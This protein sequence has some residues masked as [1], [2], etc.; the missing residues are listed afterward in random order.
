MKVSLLHKPMVRDIILDLEMW[1]WIS[2]W[3]NISKVG[4]TGLRID[5]LEKIGWW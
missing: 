5:G 2:H 1:Q 4:L 3:C